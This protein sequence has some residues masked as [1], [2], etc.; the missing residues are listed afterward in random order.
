MCSPMWVSFGFSS[1][2]PEP[3]NMQVGYAKLPLGVNVCACCP[4]MDWRPI[5]RICPPRHSH[6]IHC[7]P[8]QDR[9]IIEDYE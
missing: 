1:F 2:L 9:L 6:R 5:Q 4:A 7:D 3:K 8:D